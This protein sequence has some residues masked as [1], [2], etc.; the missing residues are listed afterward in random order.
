MRTAE[1]RKHHTPGMRGGFVHKP[2]ERESERTESRHSFV[3]DYCHRSERQNWDVRSPRVL[4]RLSFVHC[5][6]PQMS[7]QNRKKERKGKKRKGTKKKKRKNKHEEGEG[8][9]GAQIHSP[10][11]LLSAMGGAQHLTQPANWLHEQQA[12]KAS[13]FPTAQVQEHHG[14]G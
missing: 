3:D 11:F 9:E 12:T 13:S 5:L 10:P 6:L 8:G 4:Q 14:G 7:M 2:R 1:E